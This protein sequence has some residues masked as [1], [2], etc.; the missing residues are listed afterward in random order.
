MLCTAIHSKMQKNNIKA[1]LS[2]GVNWKQMQK[3][4][5]N[6]KKSINNIKINKD[7]ASITNDNKINQTIN[8]L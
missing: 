3:V 7:K 5:F 2:K 4:N 1:F 8:K 6:K